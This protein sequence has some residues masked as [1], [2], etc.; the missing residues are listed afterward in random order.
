MKY[1]ALFVILIIT[2]LFV[3]IVDSIKVK[4]AK[5]KKPTDFAEIRRTHINKIK[6]VHYAFKENDDIKI[7]SMPVKFL[8]IAEPFHDWVAKSLWTG[9][10]YNT[11]G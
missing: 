7:K 2:I 8:G 9:D 11:T 10:N 4:Q 5:I 6:I 1:F 3:N